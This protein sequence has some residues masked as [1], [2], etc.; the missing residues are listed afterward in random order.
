MERAVMPQ[1][2]CTVFIVYSDYFTETSALSKDI[3]YLHCK[4][5]LQIALTGAGDSLCSQQRMTYDKASLQFFVMPS[6]SPVI[7]IG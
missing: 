6:R 7:I 1:K 4:T 3:A 2:Y 5:G